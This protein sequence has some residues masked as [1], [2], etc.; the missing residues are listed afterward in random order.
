MRMSYLLSA[1]TGVAV[2]MVFALVSV[3]PAEAPVLCQYDGTGFSRDQCLNDC[4][5]VY[6]GDDTMPYVYEEHGRRGWGGRW[7]GW[8]APTY[9]YYSCVQRCEK[10]YWDDF[11]REFDDS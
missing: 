7:G 2:F 10:R 9:A 4:R 5:S 6:L 8:R 3:T 1:A 11:D